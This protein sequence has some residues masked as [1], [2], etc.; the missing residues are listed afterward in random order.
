MQNTEQTLATLGRLRGLGVRMTM[1]NFGTGYSS[2]G[3]L[4]KFRFDKIKIDRSFISCLAE[5]PSAEAI[6]RAV[7][8]MSESFGV[9]VNA[10]GVETK[11]QAEVLRALGCSEGQGFLYGRPISGE[12]FDL[13]VPQIEAATAR[14]PPGDADG[15]TLR[16][17]PD[18]D[19]VEP[20]ER[21]IN[22]QLGHG[23]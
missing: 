22:D 12:V 14:Q 11:T 18:T 10:E 17:A 23:A 2:L 7:I 20:A 21:M 15:C 1:D 13:L 5:D 9:L 19:L 8:G 4:Q 16:P 6:V 3:Y